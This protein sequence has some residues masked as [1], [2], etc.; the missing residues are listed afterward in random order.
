MWC[1]HRFMVVPVEVRQAAALLEKHMQTTKPTIDDKKRPGT[2]YRTE[3][4]FS[5]GVIPEDK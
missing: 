5:G 3:K 4:Y 1:C 2:L